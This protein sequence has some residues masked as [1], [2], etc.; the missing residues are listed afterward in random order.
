M[1]PYL[2]AKAQLGSVVRVARVDLVLASKGEG[3]S[4]SLMPGGPGWVSQPPRTVE[5]DE[6]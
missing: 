3:L 2:S 5:L 4:S 6:R 1:F